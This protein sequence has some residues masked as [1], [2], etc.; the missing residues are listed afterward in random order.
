MFNLNCIYLPIVFDHVIAEEINS[1]ARAVCD[2]LYFLPIV[3]FVVLSIS[4]HTMLPLSPFYNAS[5]LL[6]VFL[7]SLVSFLQKNSHCLCASV[8]CCF[9]D[10]ITYAYR[11]DQLCLQPLAPWFHKSGTMFAGPPPTLPKTPSVWPFLWLFSHAV[12]SFIRDTW[13]WLLS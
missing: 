3:F 7:H 2:K 6:P 8:Y 12:F 1:I 9:L 5:S 11:W 4:P 13:Q 10:L